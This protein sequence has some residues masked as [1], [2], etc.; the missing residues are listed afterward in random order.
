MS[1]GWRSLAEM[2][3][4]SSSSVAPRIFF[5]VIAFDGG[6]AADAVNARDRDLWHGA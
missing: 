2:S 5:R 4:L 3:A 6:S 1:S